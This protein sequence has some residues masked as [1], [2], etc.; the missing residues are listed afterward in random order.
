[1]ALAASGVE[2][3][4]QVIGLGQQ[5]RAARDRRGVSAVSHPECVAREPRMVGTEPLSMD[6]F[7]RSFFLLT[8]E[9]SLSS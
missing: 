9:A 1:M 4:T 7:L 6:C 3:A 2:R 8:L 5:V